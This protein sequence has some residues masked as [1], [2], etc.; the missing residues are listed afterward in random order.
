[1]NQKIHLIF[2]LAVLAITTACSKTKNASDSFEKASAECLGEAIPNRFMVKYLDGRLEV[3]SAS[4]KEQFIAGYLT[5]H[6]DEVE[7]AE[8][9]FRIH[10]KVNL[11][12]SLAQSAYNDNW[13]AKVVGADTLWQ[14]NVRGTDVG[15]AVIDSGMDLTHTQ[16]RKRVF[17]N[18]GEAGLDN[19]GLDRSNNGIDDDGNGFIDDAAGYDFI[20]NKP[21][22]GDYNFHGTHIAGIIAGQHTDL[23]ASGSTY[24][25]GVAPE[26]K[27]LPL[28]FLDENGSGSLAD[29]VRAIIYASSRGVKVINASWG[30]SNCSRSLKDAIANLNERGIVFVAAA[31]NERLNLDIYREYPASFDLPA[32]IT[33]GAVGENDFMADYSNYGR[34]SVHI[35][36]PGTDIISTVPGGMASLSGTSMAAPFVS[37]AVALLKSA[38]PEASPQ[39]IRD[40]LYTSATRYTD[41][42]NASQGR[43][44]LRRAL[45]EL[46]RILESF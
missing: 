10:S 43:L 6:L 35:F 8:H 46:R 22:L 11:V 36:A 3:V 18:P 33:V 20:R 19:Q 40:A 31:G 39:Q 15:V 12:N 26:A 13:G 42:L 28:A 16:L 25:Q 45:S 32:Q 21:L 7:F 14:Q 38:H 5:E 2:F 9:D 41:F 24:V 17:V 37:G 27:I 1:M 34:R 23:I 44:D 29:G 4:S 30:G